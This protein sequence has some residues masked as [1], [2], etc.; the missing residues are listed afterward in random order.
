[1][2]PQ[3]IERKRDQRVERIQLKE[4]H[5]LAKAPWQPTPSRDYGMIDFADL[6]DHERD[7]FVIRL[8][9]ASHAGIAHQH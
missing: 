1:M 2:L 4:V 7:P 8:Q 3:S 9:A 5:A 6:G